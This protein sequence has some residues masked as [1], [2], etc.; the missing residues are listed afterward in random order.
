MWRFIENIRRKP[1][2]VR[3][4][5]AFWGACVFTMLVIGVWS[6]SVPE[7]LLSVLSFSEPQVPPTSRLWSGIAEH[8]SQ[9]SA[10]I[11][12]LFESESSDNTSSEV[13]ISKQVETMNKKETETENW[14]WGRPYEE[15]SGG[16]VVQIATSSSQN[17][18]E[19]RP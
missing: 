9:L 18:V 8:S 6:L 14:V 12:G 19:E 15:R 1:E 7:R 11:I 16:Q 17:E 5:Y 2:G 3:N 4:L 10:S 13:D